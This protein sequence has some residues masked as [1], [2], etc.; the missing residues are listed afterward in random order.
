MKEKFHRITGK[1]DKYYTSF[2][3]IYAVS[4]PIFEQRDEKQQ[5]S[6]FQNEHYHLLAVIEDDTLVSFISYWDFDTYV[7]IEHLA[8]NPI[9]RGRNAGSNTLIAFAD[10]IEKTIILEIDPPVDEVSNK[11]LRFYEKLGYKT[12]PYQH[13]HPAY[14]PEHFPPHELL[15][16]SNPAGLS[17]REYEQFF[18]DL[19]DI[20]MKR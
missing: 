13:F 15:V 7:Y 20:V 10:F 2:A 14:K 6:A 9:L 18:R 17:E 19:T 8:V 16:L 4:F 1:K 11:R 3:E 5:L 12:N